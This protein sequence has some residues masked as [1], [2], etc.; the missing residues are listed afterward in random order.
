MTSGVV[1]IVQIAHS[2]VVLLSLDCVSNLNSVICMK[3]RE[4]NF[5]FTRMTN[6]LA[7]HS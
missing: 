2:E 3:Q 5:M 4:A 7:I 6:N 1:Q